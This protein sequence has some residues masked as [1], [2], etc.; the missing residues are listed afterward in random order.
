MKPSSTPLAPASG[1]LDSPITE[2]RC[3]VTERAFPHKS[4][5]PGALIGA[6]ALITLTGCPPV[7]GNGGEEETVDT[8][9]IERLIELSTPLD[10][11]LTSNIHDQQL[12]DQRLLLAELKQESPAFGRAAL[13]AY[14]EHADPDEPVIV[15]LNLLEVAAHAA[16]AETEPLMVKYIQE[17]GHPMDMRTESVRLL[18]ET[19]PIRALEVLEP[20]ATRKRATETT[21]A[22]EW[23]VSAWVTA[24]DA[25]GRSPVPVLLDIATNIYKEPYARY[26]AAT[27]LGK[28]PDPQGIEALRALLIESSGDGL[29]RRKAA[30]ALQA[31]L[32]AETACAIFQQVAENEAELG[33]LEFL[34]NM[35]QELC[36]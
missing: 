5:L 3:A 2:L 16:P 22:D 24:C 14:H 9:R 33:M 27:E 11:T 13:A 7:S 36:G 18:A 15:R 10:P 28:H 26:L 25:T 4:A 34:A 1:P 6:L 12:K 17:Y 29:L 19:N 31:A 20:Y 23:F 32:P 35:I 30:Q 8:A 21:P